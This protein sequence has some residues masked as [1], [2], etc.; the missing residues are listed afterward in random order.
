M[1]EPS[2][3]WIV[4]PCFA[5]EVEGVEQARVLFSLPILFCLCPDLSHE[6]TRILDGVIC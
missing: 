5:L 3:L 6:F 1:D 4:L 2:A